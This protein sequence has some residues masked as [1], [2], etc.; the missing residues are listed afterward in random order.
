MKLVKY[1]FGEESD[2]DTHLPGIRALDSD[3]LCGIV[4]PGI[5]YYVVDGN[6]PKCKNCIEVAI[7]IL[8]KYKIKNGII[9]AK[10]GK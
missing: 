5:P 8:G 6:T 10:V 9:A 3:T 4:F 7:Q 2:D 1:E